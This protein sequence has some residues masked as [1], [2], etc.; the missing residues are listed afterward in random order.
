MISAVICYVIDISGVMDEIKKFLW[1]RYIKTGDYKNISLKPLDCSRCGTWWIGL[2]Y[3]LLTGNFTLPLIGYVALLSLLA[4]NIT[5]LLILLKDIA[6]L[7]I[8]TIY[9]WLN[10]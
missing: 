3:I 7:A 1:K 9:R 2:L 10:I 6:T 4:S 5:D 8:T